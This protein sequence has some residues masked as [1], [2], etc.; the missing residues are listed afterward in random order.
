ML[1]HL[2]PAGIIPLGSRKAWSARADAFNAFI[3][4]AIL[5][6]THLAAAAAALVFCIVSPGLTFAAIEFAEEGDTINLYDGL[7]GLGGIF[8]VDVLGAGNVSSTAPFNGSTPNYDFPT[9]CVEIEEHISPGASNTYFVDKVSDTTSAGGKKLGSFAAWLYTAYLEAVISP[10]AA[11]LEL[12]ANWGTT[13]SH[14][15]A[16]QRGIWLSM[17]YSVSAADGSI[18]GS[19][20]NSAFFS[21]LFAAYQASAWSTGSAN[22]GNVWNYGYE[23]GQVAIMNL[24]SGTVRGGSKVQDQL[25]IIPQLPPPPGTGPLP[26]PM[27]FLVWS[28]LAMCVGSMGLRRRD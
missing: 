9:F 3:L 10:G 19:G 27:S 8:Y 16:I 6:K 20:Y 4:D 25:V 15:N 22:V 14:A 23:T 1:Q 18:D 7:G 21:S 11:G 17:G 2:P 28:M 12:V 24:T 26:E 5:M 13:A